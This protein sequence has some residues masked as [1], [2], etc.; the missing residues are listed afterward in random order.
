M[1][2]SW[3]SL[4]ISEREEWWTRAGYKTPDNAKMLG[5]ALFNQEVTSFQIAQLNLELEGLDG[6][7]DTN[8]PL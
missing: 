6:L 1:W 5:F 7:C 3:D 2:G 4:S 8:C